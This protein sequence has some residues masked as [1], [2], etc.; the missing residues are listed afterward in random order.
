MITARLDTRSLKRGLRELGTQAERARP[1]FEAL[2]A[3]LRQDQRE[4][5]RAQ[6]G[7]K[8]TWPKRAR[9]TS[10]K[11]GSPSHNK[12][13]RQRRRLLGK[14]PTAVRY[15]S[16]ADEV[17]ATSRVPWSGVHQDGGR[18]GRGAEVPARPFLWLSRGFLR[19]AGE[20]LLDYVA[21][22]WGRR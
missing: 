14:L 13:R 3:P 19:D 17:S 7:P 21:R 20:A 5:R 4:H 15:R 22:N 9:T 6:E 11:R 18:V 16:D 2:K 10:G 12:K 1:F 8:G